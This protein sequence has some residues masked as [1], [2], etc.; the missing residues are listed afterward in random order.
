MMGFSSTF[1]VLYIYSPEIIPSKIRSTVCGA[2]FFCGMIAPA[3]VLYFKT[4]IPEIFEYFFIIFGFLYSIICMY[5]PETLGI[6]N[7]DEIPEEENEK[8]LLDNN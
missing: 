5:L 8:H 4:F 3:F 2:L 1:N 7:K 6:E